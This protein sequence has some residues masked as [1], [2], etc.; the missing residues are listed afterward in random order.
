[1]G[2]YFEYGASIGVAIGVGSAKGNL[3]V[4]KLA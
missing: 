3:Q 1:M 2:F 4:M